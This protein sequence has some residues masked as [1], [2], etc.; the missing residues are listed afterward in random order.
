MRGDGVQRKQLH[1][2]SDNG[3]G[4]ATLY[5]GGGAVNPLV[6]TIRLPREGPV[7]R[8]PPARGSAVRPDSRSLPGSALYSSFVT[9]DGTISGWNPMAGTTPPPSTQAVIEVFDS[10]CTLVDS[11][12]DPTGP[13]GFAP[14]N[15]QNLG[16]KL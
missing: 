14:F 9:E 7:R 11:I 15:I 16:G 2:V 5:T 6:V 3:T 12:T 13:R 10:T 1:L 4:V 8:R